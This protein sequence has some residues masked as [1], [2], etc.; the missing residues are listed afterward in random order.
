[1]ISQFFSH[2]FAIYVHWTEGTNQGVDQ[3]GNRW[4]R[5]GNYA[6]D[7]GRVYRFRI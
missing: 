5:R 7:E 1:M 6:Y 3:F 2:G 4:T